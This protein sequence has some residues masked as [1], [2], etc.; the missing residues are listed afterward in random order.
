MR[1]YTEFD[2]PEPVEK[3]P[4]EE[5]AEYESRQEGKRLT[6]I[7]FAISIV[8]MVAFIMWQ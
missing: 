1:D 2:E 8:I 6:L 4:E 5:A 3:D 7:G